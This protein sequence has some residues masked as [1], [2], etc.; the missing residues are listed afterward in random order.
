MTATSTPRPVLILG[1]VAA[2]SLVL[3][4]GLPPLTPDQFDWIGPAVGLL[5]LAITAGLTWV[6]QQKVTPTVNVAAQILPSGQ[7]VAG[8]GTEDIP[9]GAPVA[10][11]PT[12]AGDFRHG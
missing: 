4:N 5:G 3:S 7:V 8:D 2:G 12:T 6:T 11:T 10:V 1:G 9:T